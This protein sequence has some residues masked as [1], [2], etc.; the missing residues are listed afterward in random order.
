M[1]KIEIENYRGWDISFDTDNEEFFGYSNKYDQ[2]KER[3]TLSSVRKYIDEF[4]K[5]NQHFVPVWVERIPV[6]WSGPTKKIK[7]LGIR[8]DGKF[9][10]ENQKGEKEQLSTSDEKYY[11]VYNPENEKYWLK[12]KE[13]E[14]EETI[15]KQ[16]KKEVE[17]KITGVTLDEIKAKYIQL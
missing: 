10:F 6:G 12:I 3:K 8:K 15:L 13:I 9:V 2:G 4:I 5:D 16:Q 11:V 1:A 14:E 7:L 17:A